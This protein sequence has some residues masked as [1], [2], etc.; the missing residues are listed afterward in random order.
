MQCNKQISCSLN[1]TTNSESTNPEFQNQFGI[2][3]WILRA[4]YV[5]QPE[6]NKINK[7]VPPECSKEERS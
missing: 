1:S 3:C 6:K 2:G 4:I 5:R 7:I